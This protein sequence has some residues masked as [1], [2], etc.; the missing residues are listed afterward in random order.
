MLIGKDIKD[1]EKYLSNTINTI[2]SLLENYGVSSS[3]Q[4][5]SIIEHRK[6]LW[7]NRSELD[8]IEINENCGQVALEEKLYASKISR[9]KTL[10]RQ[11]KSPYFARLII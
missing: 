4:D 3:N 10:E 2:N 5:K 7:D 1:E 8:E 9:I 11:L 6:F